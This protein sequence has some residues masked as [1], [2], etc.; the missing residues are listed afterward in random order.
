M[1][2][3]PLRAS[4]LAQA[5]AEAGALL[6]AARR[7]ADG[8]RAE[9][10]AEAEALLR[11]ATAER[12]EAS[13]AARARSLLAARR[14]ARAT[15]LRAR[16]DAYEELHAAVLAAA[17]DL[18]AGPDYPRLR[19]RLAATARERLGPGAELTEPA[20]GGVVARAGERLV[21]CSL[22]AMAERCLAGL[23]PDLEELWR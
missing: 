3:E 12:E 10:R 8:L 2:L 17:A 16:R 7:E 15:V 20:G 11:Q 19:E 23:G 4:L 13:A 21:D 9:A 1:N 22:P 5:H 6:D 18:R 14:E